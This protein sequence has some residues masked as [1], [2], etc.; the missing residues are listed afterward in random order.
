MILKQ[1][2]VFELCLES[3]CSSYLAHYHLEQR[4]SNQNR[5]VHER[6]GEYQTGTEWYMN[7]VERAKFSISLMSARSTFYLHPFF[8]NLTV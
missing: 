3:F 5:T 1:E 7:R 4:K 6:N 2:K 8:L